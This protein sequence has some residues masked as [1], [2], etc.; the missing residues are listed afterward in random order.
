MANIESACKCG[1]TFSTSGN[2]I[3]TA[4]R[5]RE[6]LEAHEICRER[7]EDLTIGDVSLQ[8]RKS[9]QAREEGE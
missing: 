3:F 8:T 6:F 7:E 5:F 2:T 4:S 1:A 9:A